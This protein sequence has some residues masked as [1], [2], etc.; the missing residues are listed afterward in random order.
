MSLHCLWALLLVG[1]T[2][3]HLQ[4]AGVPPGTTCIHQD[5]VTGWGALN[6]SACYDPCAVT[7]SIYL[8]PGGPNMPPYEPGK[9]PVAFASVHPGFPKVVAMCPTVPRNCTPVNI[10]FTW[11][12]RL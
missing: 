1:I 10:T 7:P 6:A 4:E 12:E 5:G 3:G 11:R 2:V 8:S 9:C